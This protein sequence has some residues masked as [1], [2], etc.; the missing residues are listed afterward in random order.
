MKRKVVDVDKEIL[1]TASMAIKAIRDGA[2][3]ADIAELC[4]LRVIV[5]SL[6]ETKQVWASPG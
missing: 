4:I 1:A 2:K 5:K 3:N 6:Q